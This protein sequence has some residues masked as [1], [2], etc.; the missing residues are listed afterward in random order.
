MLFQGDPQSNY[1]I[2]A[3]TNLVEW[4]PI[5][6]AVRTNGRFRIVDTNAAIFN[7]RF[8]RVIQTQ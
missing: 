3:S 5:G 2:Q 7:L 8:Y 1:E 4:F 6:T